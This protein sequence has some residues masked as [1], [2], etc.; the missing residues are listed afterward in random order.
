MTTEDKRPMVYL[1]EGHVC[2]FTL[3]LPE[4]VMNR[5]RAGHLVRVNA[6]GTPYEGAH[7]VLPDGTSDGDEAGDG[8]IPDRP[9]KNAGR[10]AWAVYAIAIGAATEEEAD[11]LTRDQLIDRCTPPEEK[12]DGGGK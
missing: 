6:D 11:E 3:P 4:A 10:T 1:R 5:W 8:G 2:G 7:F 9:R 12:P